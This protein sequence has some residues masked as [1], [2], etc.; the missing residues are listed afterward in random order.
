MWW[1][2]SGVLWV[3]LGFVIGLLAVLF[4]SDRPVK[5]EEV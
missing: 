2:W 4:L 3:H 1:L 5:A